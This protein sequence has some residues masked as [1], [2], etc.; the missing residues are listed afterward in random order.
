MRR[1]HL[2]RYDGTAAVTDPDALTHAPRRGPRITLV[3]S[4]LRQSSGE[5]CCQSG[6]SADDKP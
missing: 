2:T 3:E 5:P 6:C 1:H 4:T